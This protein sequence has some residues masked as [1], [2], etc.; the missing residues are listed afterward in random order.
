MNSKELRKPPTLP[1]QRR[2]V[3]A[4][5]FADIVGYSRQIECDQVGSAEQVSRSIGLFKNLIGD[6]GGDILNVAGDGILALFDT[7][8]GAVRFAMQVQREFR[9]QAVWR[10]GEPIEFRVGLSLGEVLFYNDNVHG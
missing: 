8:E 4:V 2:K 9:D 5:M 6:Y 10:P 7:A 1:V 3:A